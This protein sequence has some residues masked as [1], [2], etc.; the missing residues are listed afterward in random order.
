MV[1][2]MHKLLEKPKELHARF[3]FSATHEILRGR[4][5]ESVFPVKTLEGSLHR[6][7][8]NDIVQMGGKHSPFGIGSTEVGACTLEKVGTYGRVFLLPVLDILKESL[9]AEFGKVDH[10]VFLNDFGISPKL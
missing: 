1:I 9:T 7:A 5:C 6:L 2:G 3:L 8:T 10:R 4:V